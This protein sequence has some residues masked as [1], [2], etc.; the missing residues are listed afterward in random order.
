MEIVPQSTA[1]LRSHVPAKPV[2]LLPAPQIAG[3]LP[4]STTPPRD[5]KE[6]STTFTYADPRLA[7]LTLAK[8][9][10]MFEAVTQL[11]N[12][13]VGCLTG[14]AQEMELITAEAAFHDAI[15]GKPVPP[16]RYNQSREAM[17]EELRAFMDGVQQRLAVRRA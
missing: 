14:E 1:T 6:R 2:L 9:D 17:D 4:A 12:I 3:L 16:P 11:L 13:A 15:M 10:K 7:T 8:Q 5:D